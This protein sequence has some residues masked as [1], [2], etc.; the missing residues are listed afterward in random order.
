MITHPD[1]QLTVSD[2]AAMRG[3]RIIFSG[4]NI[5]VE[6]GRALTVI[7]PNGAGK[8]TLL[9]CLAGFLPAAHGTVKLAGGDD[10]RSVG[11]QCHYI[12]HLNGIK[13]ALT[14]LENLEFFANFLQ[15]DREATMNAAERLALAEL[16][17]IQAGYLSAGQKRRLGLARLV[18]AER[19]VWLLDEPAVSLDQASQALLAGLV[20]GHLAAGGIVVAV[21]HTSLGWE[22]T[23]IFDF[24]Q[25]V[26]GEGTHTE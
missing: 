9:R 7:G 6:G 4:L 26:A 5:N 19:P 25:I 18:C 8:T 15:G 3:T 1:I 12:G 13:P 14:V 24:S 2:L 23:Q 22:E 10:E 21:T 20:A 17:D 16:A 11:E